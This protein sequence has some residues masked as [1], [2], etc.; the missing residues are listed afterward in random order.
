MHH[1]NSFADCLLLYLMTHFELYWTA[2]MAS[3]GRVVVKKDV[4][5]DGRGL[6]L[7]MYQEKYENPQPEQSVFTVTSLMISE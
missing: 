4:K 5:P 2:Y 3:K 6:F 7:Y 1:A